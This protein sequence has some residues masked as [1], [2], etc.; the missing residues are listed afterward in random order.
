MARADSVPKS[1]RFVV[2]AALYFAQDVLV[3]IALA[4]LLSFLLAPLV[5]WLE[6]WRVHRVASVII[7]MMLALGVV[8]GTMYLV[9]SQVTNLATDLPK[10][11]SNIRQKVLRFRPST[12]GVFAELQKTAT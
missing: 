6:R 12:G 7:V 4:V 5:H 11:R 9:Y 8:A 1:S 10:Y 2:V 3:P